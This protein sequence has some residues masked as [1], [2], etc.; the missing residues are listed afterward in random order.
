M[1]KLKELN[2]D[3]ENKLKEQTNTVNVYGQYIQAYQEKVKELDVY[4]KKAN[5]QFEEEKENYLKEI[6]LLKSKISEYEK[7]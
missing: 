4:I 7:Q 6:E 2:Q 5:S 1:E 3:L